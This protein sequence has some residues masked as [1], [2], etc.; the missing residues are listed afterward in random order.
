MTQVAARFDFNPW[1]HFRVQRALS[2]Q[3]RWRFVFYG[4]VVG[5]PLITLGLLWL[6]RSAMPDGSL[7]IG[8]VWYLFIP[9]A[10]GLLG[11]PLAQVYTAFAHRRQHR[12]PHGEHFVELNEEGVRAG[13]DAMTTEVRWDALHR[14]CE[15]R[16]FF[17]LYY[18]P[19]CAFY[20]PK[21]SLGGAGGEAE[22]RRAIHR[23]LGERARLLAPAD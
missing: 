21:R 17:L 22:A 1:E 16:E 8:D 2:A 20:F 23:H 9:M 11:I 14:A 6:G 5:L 13:C 7:G 3:W 18:S 12:I 4:F 10:L 19:K 15:T